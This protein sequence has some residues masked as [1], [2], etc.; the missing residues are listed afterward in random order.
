M[1][2][3]DGEH[4][5]RY[6]KDIRGQLNCAHGVLLYGTKCIRCERGELPQAVQSGN[7]GTCGQPIRPDLLTGTACGCVTRDRVVQ[8]EQLEGLVRSAVEFLMAQGRMDE[9]EAVTML[10]EIIGAMNQAQAVKQ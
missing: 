9:A 6:W 1:S 4:V 3:S 10:V 8:P 5:E 2:A 7:C